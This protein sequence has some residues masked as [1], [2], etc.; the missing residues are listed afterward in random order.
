MR[1]IS[2]V[3]FAVFAVSIALGQGE[4]RSPL[5]HTFSIVARDTVTGDIGVAAHDFNRQ[6]CR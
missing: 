6:S 5:V 2:F 1:N 4:A 3:L